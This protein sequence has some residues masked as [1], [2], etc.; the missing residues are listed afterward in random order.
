MPDYRQR[1]AAL[2]EAMG[3]NDVAVLFLPVSSTLEYFTGISWPIPNPTEHD[4]PGDW[5]SGMYLGIDDGPVIVEPQMGS[6]AI[7][8]EVSDKPW[9]EDLHVLTEL[10]DYGAVLGSYVRA[11]RG[12]GSGKIALAEHS[13]AKTAIAARNA[14][15]EAEIINAHD[16]IW[17]MRMIKD[18]E[19]QQ[20][21]QAAVKLADDAY[22]PILSRLAARN[23]EG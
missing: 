5:V 21:I 8:A 15:P 23:D 10:D 7:V 1:I 16:L 4:R 18:D 20:R 13:W 22:E 3:R 9:I 19:E 17:P 14:A 6:A 12:S 2:Q 11:M